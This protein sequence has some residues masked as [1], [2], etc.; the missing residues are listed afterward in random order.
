L[1]DKNEKVRKGHYMPNWPELEKFFLPISRKISNTS[2]IYILVKL[3]VFKNLLIGC[4][5]SRVS[6]AWKKKTKKSRFSFLYS[7]LIAGF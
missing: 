3:V 2:G 5:V 4:F 6:R 7:S 1:N